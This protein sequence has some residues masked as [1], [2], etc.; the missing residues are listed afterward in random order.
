M[1]LG[2]FPVVFLLGALQG[3]ILALYLFF[4]RND[5][6]QAK[7]FLGSLILV[8]SYDMFETALSAQQISL[9]TTDLFAYSLLFTLGPSLYLTIKTSINPQRI[10]RRTIFLLYLPALADFLLSSFIF[11]LR[12]K[13]T[14]RHDLSLETF[15]AINGAH[16]ISTRLLMVVAFW[17]YFAFA[18][19]EFR[20][21]EKGDTQAESPATEAEREIIKKWLR[22]FLTVCFFIALVWTLTIYGVIFFDRERVLYFYYPLELL[23]AFLIYWIGFTAYHRIKVIYLNEQ[24]NTRQYFSKLSGEEVEAA[25]AALAKAMNDDKLYL[26]PEL[27]AQKLAAHIRHAPKTISAILNQHLETNFNEYVNQFR[28]EE[29]KRMLSDSQKADEKIISIAFDSGFNSL[30]TF[31]RVFKNLTGATPKQ[32]QTESRKKI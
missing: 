24:K 22:S 20:R 16:L 30:A 1:S 18:V 28:I 4:S 7:Y 23:L 10:A 32:F 15:I 2:L 8:L 27:T 12:F 21:F 11:A 6:R 26:D 5:E 13:Q 25:I 31:Q 19:K 14:F 3:L 9:F 17:V 29:A